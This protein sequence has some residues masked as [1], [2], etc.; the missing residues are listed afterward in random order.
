M[1]VDNIVMIVSAVTSAIALY[2]ATKKQKHEEA[3]IDSDTINKLYATIKD[4]DE[5]N[6][7]L[8]DIFD[9]RV[10][11]LEARIT[12]LEEENELLK[13]WAERLVAQVKS[14]GHEPVKIKST[15]KA[16]R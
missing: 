2:Y 3:S 15:L 16:Q 10:G 11:K 1:T 6:N 8:R 12:A 13:D 4:Q 14:L 7:Q 5:R 9:A